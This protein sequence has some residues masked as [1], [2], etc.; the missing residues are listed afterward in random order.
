MT[1]PDGRFMTVND[2]GMTVNSL[3][4]DTVNDWSVIA[5]LMPILETS[6]YTDRR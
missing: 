2:E 5:S 1:V 4:S 6:V 3:F